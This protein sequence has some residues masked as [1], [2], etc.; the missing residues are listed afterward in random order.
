MIHLIFYILLKTINRKLL[1]SLLFISL[2]VPK[3][4]SPLSRASAAPTLMTNKN[5]PQLSEKATNTSKS[6]KSKKTRREPP[7]D[8]SRAGG[9]RGCPGRIKSIPLTVLAPR[10]FVGETTLVRPTFT[11]F[12]SKDQPTEFRLF[13]LDTSTSTP[14]KIGSPIPH[15]S[16]SGI[17]KLSLPNS[18]P[19]LVVGKR[20]IWQV[21]IDCPDGPFI[22]RAEFKVVQTPANLREKLSGVTN[23]SQTAYSQK[24]YI[25]AKQD[26]WYEA[27]EEALQV[28]PQG[29]LQKIGYDIIRDLAHSDNLIPKQLAP[30]RIRVLEKEIQQRKNHLEKIAREN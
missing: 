5:N 21:S 30:D 23:N 4:A 19:A 28:A 1:I 6:K 10:T 26:L 8:Y 25:Y 18:Q 13:E 2:I 14:I 16:R 3:L 15:N 22:Q 11:W 27:L 24:A 9:S 20:Y 12:V 7:S 29:K 17:N